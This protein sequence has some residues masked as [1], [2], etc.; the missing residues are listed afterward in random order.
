[1]ISKK[2]PYLVIPKL[3][4]QPT[5]GGDYIL[6][7]KKWTDIPALQG[8]KIG[9]S[10]ELFGRS[11][12]LLDIT[13]TDFNRFLPEFGMTDGNSTGEFHLIEGKDYITLRHL[14]HDMPLLVKLNQASGNS[15]QLHIKPGAQHSRWKPKPESWYYLEDGFLS[16]GIKKGINIDEYKKTC[17][18]I[19]DK[20]KELS[21]K[22][23]AGEMGIEEAK[24]ISTAYI[25]ELNPWQYVNRYDAKKYSLVDL[26]MGGLHHS[27]E[28]DKERFPR[29]NVVYEVQQ[30]V[31]DPVCTIRSF[32]QGKF[33]SDGAI[34]EIHI[35]DYFAALDTD[36][37]HNDFANA[38]KTRVGNRL[39]TTPYYCMDIIEVDGE[40]SATTGK[41]F[42][43]LFVRD[44]AVEVTCDGGSVRVGTGHSCFLPQEA[45]FFK[46]KSMGKQAVVL[47]TYIE[48]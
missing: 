22:I 9:Q 26:S 8:K 2:R 32:D 33:K 45:G 5:W 21:L 25:K 12:L 35:D 39:L 4:E 37:S 30:D 42:V 38:T 48:K 47:K 34:R 15:F 43:H 41:S 46:I 18:A 40:T 3:I 1:M 17:H 29:G 36:E 11:K 13:D 14:V 44:G 20:M 24:K 31:M 27:W 28:E 19:N 6:Q 23:I 16:F 7:M 10:Y